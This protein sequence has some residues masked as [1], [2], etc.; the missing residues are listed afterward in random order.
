MSDMNRKIYLKQWIQQ[1]HLCER[2]VVV[3]I[4]STYVV[5]EGNPSSRSASTVRHKP[6][7]IITSI[8]TCFDWEEEQCSYVH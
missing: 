1:C 3:I 6:V 2:Y 8:I 4:L 7:P 5:Q